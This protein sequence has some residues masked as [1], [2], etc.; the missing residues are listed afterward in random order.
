VLYPSSR[1]PRQDA[2]DHS[3][4]GR[5]SLDDSISAVSVAPQATEDDESPLYLPSMQCEFDK[6][7]PFL[8]AAEAWKVRHTSFT[9]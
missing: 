7:I 3:L 9:N 2:T 5:Y 8:T 1:S 4:N 6:F